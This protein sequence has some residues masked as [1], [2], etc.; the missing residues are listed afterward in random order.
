M[1]ENIFRELFYGYTHKTLS[2]S[3]VLRNY[4]ISGRANFD[5]VS[6]EYLAANM[7]MSEC[8]HNGVTLFGDFRRRILSHL[9]EVNV[10][11]PDW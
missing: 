8:D 2:D 6:S 10:L 4:S 11:S 3:E 5:T 1:V 9:D 7:I